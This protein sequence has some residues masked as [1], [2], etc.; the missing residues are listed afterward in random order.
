MFHGDLRPAPVGDHGAEDAGY[1]RARGERRPAPFGDLVAMDPGE[2]TL[3]ASAPRCRV[4]SKVRTSFSFLVCRVPTPISL[5]ILHT[6]SANQ[7]RRGMVHCRNFLCSE[8]GHSTFA[9]PTADRS[10]WPP[11]HAGWIADRSHW[12]LQ[13]VGRGMRCARTHRPPRIA[14]QRTM[15]RL[16][17]GKR[18]PAGAGGYAR[19]NFAGFGSTLPRKLQGEDLFL[20]CGL[21]R[22]YSFFT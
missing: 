2:V 19:I 12:P 5:L 13:H 20:F 16:G 17:P 9:W 3:L 4:N 14:G 10:R 22:S 7:M 6:G 21:S 18:W 8:G 11:W 15:R 1:D